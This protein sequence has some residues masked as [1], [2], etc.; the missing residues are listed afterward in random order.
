M[1]FT[2]CRSIQEAS[3]AGLIQPVAFDEPPKMLPVPQFR[4]L[5]QVYLQDVLMRLPDV[6]AEITST[7]GRILKMDSTKKIVNKLAGHVRGTAMW[8]TNV[9]N[10]IGQVLI[11]V[12][13]TGE[14][15][16]L[17]PMAEGMIIICICHSYCLNII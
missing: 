3:S 10:E 14:G 5:M 13:T 12:I 8:A 6:K 7:L 11:S 9:G 16:A 15:H 4:W 17:I 1:V 2:N